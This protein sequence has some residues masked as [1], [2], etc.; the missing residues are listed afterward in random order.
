MEPCI[1]WRTT[2][3]WRNVLFSA[4]EQLSAA[5]IQNSSFKWNDGGVKRNHRPWVAIWMRD[6]YKI[7]MKNMILE[8]VRGQVKSSSGHLELNLLNSKNSF[9]LFYQLWFDERIF[10]SLD[11]NEKR[12]KGWLCSIPKLVSSSFKW[13]AGGCVEHDFEKLVFI[14]SQGCT[15]PP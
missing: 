12:R 14:K 8:I 13:G 6:L 2:K 4:Q 5:L 15:I 7:K 11:W 3:L 10:P 9:F 1:N